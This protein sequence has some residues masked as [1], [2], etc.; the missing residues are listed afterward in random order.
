MGSCPLRSPLRSVQWQKF[1]I[2]TQHV[3]K[4]FYIKCSELRVPVGYNFN[5]TNMLL[6]IYAPLAPIHCLMG[7]KYL[8][9]I[10]KWTFCHLYAPGQ[11][12]GLRDTAT[13]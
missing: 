8:L 6:G 1:P 7:T 4:S 5:C 10:N 13:A 12:G 9:C 3:V 11:V 2:F